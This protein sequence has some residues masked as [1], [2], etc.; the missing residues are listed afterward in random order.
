MSSEEEFLRWLNRSEKSFIENFRFG[1]KAWN[2]AEFTLSIKY[3]LIL[4]WLASKAA[5]LPAEQI[6]HDEFDELLQMRAQPGLIDRVTKKEFAEMM[7]DLAKKCLQNSAQQITCIW[8]KLLYRLCEFEVLQDLYRTD[9]DIHARVYSSLLHGYELY[10]KQFTSNQKGL[11]SATTR[12]MNNA[13]ESEFFASTVG[14]LRDHVKRTGN[15]KRY[16]H[17]YRSFILQ[18][19]VRVILLLRTHSLCFFDELLQLERL[20]TDHLPDEKFVERITILP[21]PVRLVTLE[22]GIVNRRGVESFLQNLIQH[23]FKELHTEVAKQNT[24]KIS[25]MLTAAAYTLEIF[26]KYDINLNFKMDLGNQTPT[27]TYLGEQLLTCIQ[28]CKQTH[29]REVLMLLCAALR[30]NPLILE[31]DIFQITT[32]MIVAEKNDTEDHILFSEYLVALMDMFRRL[33]RA[34]KLVFNLLKSLK[35]WLNK[36]EILSTRKTPRNLKRKSGEGVETPAKK[37]KPF[38]AT[39][40]DESTYLHIIFKEFYNI[41]P[42]STINSTNICEGNFPYLRAAWP[43]ESVGVAFSKLIT[44]LVS[45]P[46][47]VIW[48]SLLYSLKELLEKLLNQPDAMREENNLFLL[49]LH[50]ALLCQYFSGCRLVEQ[51]DKFSNEVDEQIRVTERVLAQYGRLLLSQGHNSRTT[52]AFLECAFYVTNFELLLYYYRPDGF[53]SDLLLRSE[54]IHAFLNPEEWTS[55]QERV[56][57]F[58]KSQCKFLFNRLMLQRAQ[59]QSLVQASSNIKS[60]DLQKSLLTS[61]ADG[62]LPGELARLLQQVPSTK[63]F[64]SHLK[65]KQKDSILQQLL[66]APTA[67][68][69]IAEDLALLETLAVALGARLSQIFGAAAKGSILATLNCSFDTLNA[70][71]HADQNMADKELLKLI[72]IVDGHAAG[73]CKLSQ[74]P[75]VEEIQKIISLC[76]QLP[77]GHLRKQSKIFVFT[78]FLAFYSDLNRLNSTDFEKIAEEV[79]EIMIDFLHFGQHVPIFKYFALTTIFKILPVSGAWQFYEYVFHTIKCEEKGSEQFLTSYASNLES[80]QSSDTKLSDDQRRLLLIAIETLTAL[81]GPAAKR[82]RKHFERMLAIYSNY[83]TAYFSNHAE[84]VNTDTS[85][86]SHAKKYKR[87]VEKTLAGFAPF[88]NALLTNASADNAKGENKSGVIVNDNFRR[89]CKIYIGHSMDYRN[90]HAIRLLQVALNHRQ[91]LHLD[92]DEIEFVLSHYWEQ[93]NA[94]L[95]ASNLIEAN[96]LKTT[97]MTVK[98]IIGNKTNE[99]L[100]LTLHSLAKN[101]DDLKEFRNILRCLELVAKC[102]FSTIKG[103]IFN[104]KFK[105]ITCNIILRLVKD[106]KQQ[107]VDKEQVFAILA[108]QQSLVENKMIP[109][110]MDTIDDILAFL[111]DINIKRF[112]LSENN[113]STFKRLHWSMTDLVGGLIRQR[114]VLLMDRVPQFTHIFKDLIQS[115]VWYKSDRQKDAAL[116]STELEDL[117]ELAMKVEA[118]MHLIAAH[119]VHVKRVAPFVLTFVIGLMVANKR[120]TTLYP[121]IKTHIDN[122][123]YDLIGICDHRVGRFILRCSNEAARQVYELYVKDHKKYHKFKGKV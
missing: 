44:G 76:R 41:E 111:M 85:V 29:L 57:S 81:G 101:L 55:L 113:L 112:A 30:L 48:R 90:P 104:E 97:E 52:C 47:L 114:H 86:D 65:E 64:V 7:L 61:L 24:T 115:I 38:I 58:G 78:L 37:P 87:F 18:P 96:A 10:L 110:S 42:R 36:F 51:C 35:E 28:Q 71:I 53:E 100:L 56:Q 99:D 12:V 34:E 11:I 25:L 95:N 31:Q 8:P 88:A 77:L 23:V 54:G 50:S 83:I 40:N 43:T 75:D 89:I 13:K 68:K 5:K 32:W 4:S 21:L 107:F 6:P 73:D 19:L 123:C 59:A 66:D 120:A 84:K 106:E 98:M 93:L 39:S 69:A 15:T 92:Q 79:F 2:S 119:S 116:S 121:K 74:Q 118:L 49:D 9:Y 33:S 91:L 70:Y 109:I 82:M 117:A 80:T 108:A 17:S 102:S 105:S 45:K 22:C 72:A 67:I 14:N 16:D 26:R 27:M 122:V 63:W 46:A 94:D 3:Q 1:L 60:V 103:A 62:Q 20:L